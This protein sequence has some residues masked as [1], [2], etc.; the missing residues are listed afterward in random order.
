MFNKVIF[1]IDNNTDFHIVAKFMRHVDT[2]R[3]MGLV[4]GGI[5]MATGYW[6]G[7]LEASYIMDEI[8]YRNVVEPM[9]FT[10]KQ[11]CIL[12]V[13]A[14]TR[15]PCTLEYGDDTPNETIGAMREISKEEAL[16]GF[17]WTY[18]QETDK[19]FATV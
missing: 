8:D 18:V 16:E 2:A 19:Y 11:V 1:A 10:K 3:S 15:Q 9:G 17:A 13:P 7:E 14:D 6:E 12:H 4:S 5:V